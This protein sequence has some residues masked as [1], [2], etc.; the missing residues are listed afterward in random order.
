MDGLEGYFSLE[1]VVIKAVLKAAPK[2]NLATKT[3][4][5][6]SIGKNVINIGKAAGDHTLVKNLVNNRNASRIETDSYLFTIFSK[7]GDW[8]DKVSHGSGSYQDFG[9]VFTGNNNGTMEFRDHAGTIL[10]H[11]D[12]GPLFGAFNAAGLDPKIFEELL[13]SSGGIKYLGLLI[14]AS[15]TSME[16]SRSVIEA[17]KASKE[18]HQGLDQ[19]FLKKGNVIYHRDA[20]YKTRITDTKRHSV[21]TN[22]KATDTFPREKL[23]PYY[24]LPD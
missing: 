21:L 17:I 18:I 19:M 13:K 10:D 7:M 8:L 1:P 6:L 5:A 20:G 3:F 16:E 9:I 14:E 4:S 24:P 23:I 15:G 2:I 22:E 11:I 12:I